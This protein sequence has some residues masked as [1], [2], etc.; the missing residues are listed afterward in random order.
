MYIWIILLV[1]IANR[2]YEWFK[3]YF[4]ESLATVSLN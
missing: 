3:Q 1:A 2:K 4:S